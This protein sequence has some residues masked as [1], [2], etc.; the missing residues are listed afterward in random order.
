MRVIVQRALGALFEAERHDHQHGRVRQN[1]ALHALVG[2][3]HREGLQGL[4]HDP[5][6]HRRDRRYQHV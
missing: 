2:R 6:F 4:C 5:S 3:N 1:L